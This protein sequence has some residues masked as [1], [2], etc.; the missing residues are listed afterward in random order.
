MSLSIDQPTSGILQITGAV[1]VGSLNGSGTFI[2]GIPITVPSGVP[3]TPDQAF[4]DGM[5]KMMLNFNLN[6]WL[7]L[8]DIGATDFIA[9]NSN[10]FG[11][12]FAL[13]QFRTGGTSFN[14]SGNAMPAQ[15]VQ[16]LLAELN[17]AG[18]ANSTIDISG[19]TNAAP[20]PVPETCILTLPDIFVATSVFTI[21]ANG[22][23]YTI[24]FDATIALSD[25]SVSGNDYTIGILDTPSK[26]AVASKIVALWVGAGEFTDNLDGTITLNDSTLSHFPYTFDAGTTN[27]SINETS[28]GGPNA[29]QVTL[30]GNGC[31]V[32]TN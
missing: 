11:T 27:I 10:Q 28:T 6:Y 25:S 7:V 24:T 3:I 21:A 20:T 9:D 12:V 8:N 13:L 19:G 18:V 26:T 16:K 4:V 1:I 23:A 29:E 22:T 5:A 14:F 15:N 32:I 17:L 30:E 31:T 2:P